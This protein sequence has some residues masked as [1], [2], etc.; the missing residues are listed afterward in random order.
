[1]IPPIIVVVISTAYLWL[2]A[3]ENWVSGIRIWKGSLLPVLFFSM[4][5]DIREN[6]SVNSTT[7]EM[8]EFAE[9][10]RGGFL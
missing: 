9:S 6:F 10:L 7:R 8:Q 2:A 4:G 1:M 5:E 3:L